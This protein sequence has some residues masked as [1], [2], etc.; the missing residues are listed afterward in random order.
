MIHIH[1]KLNLMFFYL[2]ISYNQMEIFYLR[3]S[4]LFFILNENYNQYK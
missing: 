1:L 2:R 4:R 3:I